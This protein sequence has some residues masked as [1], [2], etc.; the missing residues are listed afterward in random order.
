MDIMSD[1]RPLLQAEGISVILGTTKILTGANIDLD[2]GEI[3]AITGPSGSGKSTL[4][5]VLAGLLR[6]DSG[7]L[8]F[9]GERMD[10]LAE[11][12]IRRIRRKNFGF[13]LQSSELLPELTVAENI[14]LPLR[15]A[16]TSRSEIKQRVQLALEQLEIGDLGKRR[17][18]EVSGGQQQRAAIARAF[19]HR[20]KI[21]FADEPTGAL[22]DQASDLVFSL[23]LEQ[24]RTHN[25]GTIIVTHSLSLA[26]SCD[27]HLRVLDGTL[28]PAMVEKV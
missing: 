28:V 1:A 8:S 7:T 3:L 22:D 6:P 15:F 24:C 26:R 4:M 14:G 2:G 9:S 17:L 23:F 21:I 20:P 13:V 25:V 19:I 10:G 11:H 5:H 27:R 16:G 12:K 18:H